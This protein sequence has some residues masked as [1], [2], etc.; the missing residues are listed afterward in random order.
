[1][2]F[3]PFLNTGLSQDSSINIIYTGTFREWNIKYLIIRL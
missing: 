3:T 2:F 1:M